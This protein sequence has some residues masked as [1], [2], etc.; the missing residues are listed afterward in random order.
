[1]AYV[2][3]DDRGYGYFDEGHYLLFFEDN[4][5]EILF[6]YVVQDLS[7]LPDLF[8]QYT[9]QRMDIA[10]FKLHDCPGGDVAIDQMKRV[11]ID[12]HPYYRHEVREVLIRAIGDYFNELLLYSCYRQDGT[13]PGF[14]EEW[15]ME[16]ITAL[17]APLLELGDTYP[18]DFY[19]EYQERT[20]GN[21]YTAGESSEEIET[22]IPGVPREI[23]MGFSN[24]IQTQSEIYNMLYFLLDI[25][26]PGLETLTTPQRIWLYGNIVANSGSEMTV[27]KRLS[28]KHP[29]L[30]QSGH[31]YS[32]A[33]ERSRELDDKFSSLYAL[34]KLNVGRDGIPADIE[35]SFQSAIEYA[36]TITVDKPYEEYR[37]NSLRQLLYLEVW[38]MLQDRVM[39]RKCRHCGKYFVVA[40]RRI[41]YCDRV[42]EAGVRCSAVGSQQ[43]F[44]KKMESDE[45]L[46]IYNRAYK[47]HH[48]RVRKGTMSKEDF[49]LWY[50]EAKERM[51]R[52]RAGE[53]DIAQFQEWLKK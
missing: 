38:S 25:A 8:D 26:A 20:G 31:D 46:L 19:N 45:A 9:S 32:Q 42:D 40:N 47:T 35:E 50:S 49:E 11:L 10:T 21:A 1:M 51:E 17:L 27:P 36:R 53:L 28:L 16:R 30:Y 13:I 12:A 14:S 39:V 23:P 15:Y 33:V 7:C 6:H 2:G 24:E 18:R 43:S 22:V 52:A 41:A 4:S 5:H 3:F 44:Q 29:T 48:A 34:S 37:I